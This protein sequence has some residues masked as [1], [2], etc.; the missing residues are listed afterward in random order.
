MFRPMLLPVP[1]PLDAF[2]LAAGFD[3]VGVACGLKASGRSDVALIVADRACTAA[4]VFTTN[5]VVAAPVTWD[6]ALL[7]GS[8]D[9]LRAIVAN[10]GCANACTGERGD[11]DTRA[12]AERVGRA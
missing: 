4:G 1:I 11:A 3:A 6:R 7:D 5:R 8:S 12:T 10:S 9:A 2:T